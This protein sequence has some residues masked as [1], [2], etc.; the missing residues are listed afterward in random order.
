MT[1]SQRAAVA[2]TLLPH[3]TETVSQNR[4]EK[5]RAAWQRKREEG[6]LS[7]LTS[8]LDAEECPVSS[9][10][11][12]AH[13]MRVSDGYVANALRIQQD[14]PGLWLWHWV[15]PMYVSSASKG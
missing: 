3:I 11:I 8:N 15:G 10:A 7:N 14:A 2:V 9:R 13:M 12:A 4:I 6:C 1:T 5:V